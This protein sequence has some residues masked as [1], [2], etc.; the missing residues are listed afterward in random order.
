MS[1]AAKQKLVVVGAGMVTQRLV[2]ALDARGATE[3][4]DIE[5]FGE[6]SRPPYDRVALTSFFSDKD[7]ED[8]LL[9]DQDL[10][11]RPGVRLHRNARVDAIDPAGIVIGSVR[12]P[13]AHTWLHAWTSFSVVLS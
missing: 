2:E 3:T 12:I 1:E 7:P 6:E 10:W 9:G 11:K 8:L 5:V 4:W 13:A